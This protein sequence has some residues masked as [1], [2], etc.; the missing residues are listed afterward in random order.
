[1]KVLKK[2]LDLFE[3]HGSKIVTGVIIISVVIAA[4][5][6]ATVPHLDMKTIE[7]GK[8]DANPFTNSLADLED[9][10][11][12]PEK[13]DADLISE[14]SDIVIRCTAT[15]NREYLSTFVVTEVKIEKTYK[16]DLPSGTTV[17]VVEPSYVSVYK[18]TMDYMY[19]SPGG[20][21]LMLPGEEYILFLNRVLDSDYYHLN[22][23]GFGKYRYSGEDISVKLPDDHQLMY[24]EVKGYDFLTSSQ[25]VLDLY[26]KLWEEVLAEYS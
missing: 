23:F 4:L 11:L 6:R 14:G 9:I 12:D 22:K 18:K 5:L 24:S 21:N 15:Q 20:Y 13:A 8:Y 17:K 2:V 1:M 10:D 16:G 25:E 26:R 3:R 7:A 19:W